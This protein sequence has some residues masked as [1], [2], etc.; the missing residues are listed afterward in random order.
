MDRSRINSDV[1]EQLLM[2]ADFIP[3]RAPG[4][5]PKEF[6]QT[7]EFH[8]RGINLDPAAIVHEGGS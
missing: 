8:T 1:S 4:G 6:I 7:K 2:K 5:E 3:H